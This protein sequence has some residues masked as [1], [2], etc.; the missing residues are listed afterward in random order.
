M[1]SFADAVTQRRRQRRSS[2]IA[3]WARPA[4]AIVCFLLLLAPGARAAVTVNYGQIGHPRLFVNSNDL[5]AIR[6]LANN[7]QTQNYAK[8][9]TWRAWADQ[10]LASDAVGS[11]YK[12]AQYMDDIAAL[13][14]LTGNTAYA[15][16]AIEVAMWALGQGQQTAS[17]GSGPGE[18]STLA[19]VYDWCYDQL[20]AQQKTSISTALATSARNWPF[21]P[22]LWYFLH[23]WNWYY[24]FAIVDD[25]ST[26]GS[27]TNSEIRTI[28]EDYINN[29]NDGHCDCLDA[30]SPMGWVESYPGK[31]T[32]PLLLFIES[33]RNYTDWNPFTS[34]FVSHLP[35]AWVA[36]LRPDRNFLRSPSKYNYTLSDPLFLFS[37][38]GS[39][40]NHRNSQALVESMD[41]T[42]LNCPS[43][44]CDDL[45]LYLFYH[46]PAKPQ[47][48]LL[49]G[50]LTERQ[51]DYYDD[52]S[53]VYIGRSG[54]NLS[55]TS[56]DVMVGFFCGP[57]LFPYNGDR[58][59]GHFVVSRN[60]D[61][62]LID[63]GEYLTDVD[64][65]YEPYYLRTVAHNALLIESPGQSWGSYSD[66]HG[67]S[68]PYP[69]DGGQEDG[70]RTVGAQKWPECQNG[71]DAPAFGGEITKYQSTDSYVLI[72]ADM[73]RSY[74]TRASSVTRRWV[75]Y[76]P[77]WILVQDRVVMNTPV[78]DDTLKVLYHC[79]DRPVV[80]GDLSVI[81]GDLN[82]G[83]VFRG[84]NTTQA[85]V[86]RGDSS[87]R[88]FFLGVN[89]GANTEVRL[90][91]GTNNRS[92]ANWG[93]QQAHDSNYNE[94]E[95]TQYY[96]TYSPGANSF[97]FFVNGK[98]FTP[99]Q[100]GTCRLQD[101]VY[102]ERNSP[103]VGGDANPTGDWRLEYVTTPVSQTVVL[104]TLIHVT[105]NG[106][107]AEQP[108]ETVNQG[109]TMIVRFTDDNGQRIS[110]ALCPPGT[111]CESLIWNQ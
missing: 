52:Q 20:T 93:W 40:L 55:P 111:E 100:A 109:D 59:L 78:S 66:C 50:G 69:N 65:Q 27:V 110:L 34:V 72:E 80:N 101:D 32:S 98:N 54:Y 19:L 14:L 22:G 6:S 36:R 47:S 67:H 48:G 7:P 88:I 10:R 15:T 97:E 21:S 31:R 12:T 102:A 62:L 9:Q 103:D 28:F 64:G 104:S 46:D 30:V 53:G 60:K 86:N 82:Y 87:A 106:A 38:F 17:S 2:A 45:Y 81:L 68:F 51:L 85:T 75:Y 25:A 5:V 56:Q 108:L 77:D 91:G 18:T 107:P 42:A 57:L 4:A 63:S 84:R 23:S 58:P 94:N 35:D 49:T 37:Y 29:Y 1:L 44:Y 26:Y 96:D 39:R 41:D 90:V 95:P 24:S 99:S 92:T 73:S 33:I 61:C 3:P 71:P 43:D 79:V 11:G 89:G 70:S 8:L 76:R 83:G 74:Q 13:Y 105:T 16:R